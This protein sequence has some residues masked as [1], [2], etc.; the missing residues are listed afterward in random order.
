MK[1]SW[2]FGLALHTMICFDNTQRSEFHLEEK[3]HQL[4][5]VFAIKK[6]RFQNLCGY[7]IGS[8]FIEI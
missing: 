8:E 4:I 2:I 3:E 1:I 6:C 7:L 5:I